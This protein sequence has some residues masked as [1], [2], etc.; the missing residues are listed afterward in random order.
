MNSIMNFGGNVNWTEWVR[1]VFQYELEY[2]QLQ[3]I[4]VT[5]DHEINDE[6]EKTILIKY[7]IFHHNHKVFLRKWRP[8]C[9]VEDALISWKFEMFT[10]YT[11]WIKD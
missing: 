9:I 4:Q 5:F 2:S 7:W 10:V 8:T 11:A 1:W 3:S 6:T